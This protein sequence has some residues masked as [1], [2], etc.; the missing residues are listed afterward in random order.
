MRRRGR[1][2]SCG[3]GQYGLLLDGAHAAD[4]LLE[5]SAVMKVP[6]AFI[7]NMLNGFPH[8]FPDL[9]Q[10]AA[11]ALLGNLAAFIQGGGKGDGAVKS[12][13]VRQTLAINARGERVMRKAL[14]INGEV[15]SN[16]EQAL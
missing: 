12:A 3:Q 9:S 8:G 4:V 1:I 14:V 13:E 16:E 15:V 10:E 6:D 5:G 2:A 7:P 11:M